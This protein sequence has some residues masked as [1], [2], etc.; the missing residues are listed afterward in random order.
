MRL[1]PLCLLLAWPLLWACGDHLPESLGPA[2]KL[3]VLADA[4][5]WETLQQPVRDIFETVIYTPQE[6]YLFEVERGD[7]H[8]LDE[9]RYLLRKSLMVIAPID[10]EHPTSLFLKEILSADVLQS[11][12]Q[13]KT[14]VIWKRDVWARDQILMIASGNSLL[15]V[16]D[17]LWLS[18]D[19]LYSE[20]EQAV[21]NSVRDY[22]YSFGEREPLTREL[23]K[24][25]GWS[26]R[27]PFGYRILESYPDSGFVVLAKDNP[28]RWLFVYSEDGVHPDQITDEWC[29]QKRD[30][31]TR[32]F[33]GGDHI[34][35]VIT[36]QEVFAGKLAVVLQGLWENEAEW[37]GG[38]FKS[39]AF[40]DID[41]NR[42]FYIDMGMYAPNRK[43]APYLHQVEQIAR[44]FQIHR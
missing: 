35:N 16:A 5:D 17:N 20:L 41:L 24:T 33:F 31:I 2:R 9:Q 6:E 12:R 21:D 1:L 19:R 18:S 10:A 40:V 38:P 3:V 37:K 11:I 30:E 14:S 4:A 28:N 23:E 32:R 27:V 44:T 34:G 42:F 43:K 25:F 29:I 13:G 26:M 7:V 15:E 22:V 8:L 36:R 39:Y